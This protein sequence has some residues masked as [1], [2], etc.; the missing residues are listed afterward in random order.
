MNCQILPH[1]P[2]KRGKS[3]HHHQTLK[4]SQRIWSG[5][6]MLSRHSVRTYQGNELTHNSSGN[7]YSQSSQHTEPLWTDLG[8][9]SELVYLNWSPITSPS[10]K[11]KKPLVHVWNDSLN[12][13]LNPCMPGRSH[14]QRGLTMSHSPG[15][16]V[17]WYSI[18]PVLWSSAW[19]WDWPALH[20]AACWCPPP[21]WHCAVAAGQSVSSWPDP[22]L[23]GI[24]PAGFEI[25]VRFRLKPLV[26]MWPS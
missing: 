23:C 4:G 6:T 13:P 17:R 25:Q 15:R 19:T 3:H 26:S 14:H 5:L 21:S 11:K 7:A 24:P 22:S 2:R 10:K 8:Q 1:N 9:Q 16:N 12:L 18:L 20:F